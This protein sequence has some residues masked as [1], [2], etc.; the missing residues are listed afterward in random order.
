M[1]TISP[2]QPLEAGD[3]I[4]GWIGRCLGLYDGLA[5]TASAA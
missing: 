1:R 3:P 5:G 4:S 2:L